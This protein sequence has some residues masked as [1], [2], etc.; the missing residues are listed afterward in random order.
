V[1]GL[2]PPLDRV[3]EMASAYNQAIRTVKPYGPYCLVGFSAGSVVAYEM[4][5]QLY[6]AG[7]EVPVLALID[8]APAVDDADRAWANQAFSRLSAILH[9][10]VEDTALRA[11]FAATVQA[12]VGYRAKPYPGRVLLFRAS[13]PLPGRRDPA[14][15]WNALALG[16]VVVK[17]VEGGHL[18]LPQ[19]PAVDEVARHLASVLAEV[20]RM[21]A[22]CD[23][24]RG[25]YLVNA[26]R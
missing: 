15:V 1:D 7:H 20:A 9:E 17:E 5:Q 10:W 16:G 14:K 11:V 18:D 13:V 8:H 6:E 22:C 19:P 23:A 12:V 26:E 3:E 2:F 21:H 24:S 25:P 4:A